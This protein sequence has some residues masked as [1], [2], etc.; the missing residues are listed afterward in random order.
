MQEH[1]LVRG[2]ARF[3]VIGEGLIRMEYA[4]GGCFVDDKTLFA[5][6]REH[7]GSPFSVTD[8]D[9]VL[10][11]RTARIVLTYD[12]GKGVG[13]TADTLKAE[14]VADDKLVDVWFAG[15]KN[16]GNLGGTKS[17]LDGVGGAVQ[18]KEGVVSRDGWYLLNDSGTPLLA[19]GWIRDRDEAHVAD[20][21]L[22]S[23]G[24]DYKLAL[25]QLAQV[26]GKMAMPRRA[27][28]G[29]WYSRWHPYTAKDFLELADEYD[30][31][32]FPLDI[33]VMDMDWH[34]SKWRFVDKPDDPH[35]AKTGFGWGGGDLNWTGY[36]GAPI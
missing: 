24:K 22:F 12:Y 7:D 30:K 36:C 8:E 9:G 19:D 1:V 17:T 26:S 31:H 28:F 18:V 32:D 25:R 5:E 10:T 4:E 3:T 35:K 20:W 14:I 11:V 21:Y 16:H 2:D 34:W 29:S 13:F 33:L 27:V 15:K 23:Y 6:C